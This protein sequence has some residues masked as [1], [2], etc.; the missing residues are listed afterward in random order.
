MILD[1]T[2]SSKRAWP[3][4]ADVRMDRS[5]D[6]KPDVRATATRLPFADEVFN[7]VY[8]DPPHFVS[9]GKKDVVWRREFESAQPPEFRRFS[10]WPTMADWRYFAQM[11]AREFSRVLK[12]G[13]LLHYKAPSAEKSHGRMIP[14]TDLNYY[15]DYFVIIR[16][17][18]EESKSIQARRNKK[19][20][21]AGT[22]IWYT[23]MQKRGVTTSEGAGG[24]FCHSGASGGRGT[25]MASIVNPEPG[26]RHGPPNAIIKRPVGNTTPRRTSLNSRKAGRS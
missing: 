21:K 15:L 16:S 1:A 14:W 20:G 22:T 23:T 26:G 25:V 4:Y 6:A 17:Y 24:T 18:S 7:E 13:G 2:C 3:Q 19:M 11:S 12:P 10:Y 5:M 9:F 8:C